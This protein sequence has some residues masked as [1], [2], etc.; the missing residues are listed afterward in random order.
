M[1]LVE[2]HADLARVANALDRIAFLL[3]KLV[4]VPPEREVRVE[5][6]TLDDLYRAHGKA[7]LINGPVTLATDKS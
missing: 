7:E 3:E 2:F 5:Q 4:T 6:A 1:T